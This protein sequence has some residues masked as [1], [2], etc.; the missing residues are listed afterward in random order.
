[1]GRSAPVSK[2]RRRGRETVT[3]VGCDHVLPITLEEIQKTALGLSG[4]WPFISQ[5]TKALISGS[6]GIPSQTRL[7][8]ESALLREQHPHC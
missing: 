1:M 4:G 3:M 6:D 2:V 8:C 7:I 5:G